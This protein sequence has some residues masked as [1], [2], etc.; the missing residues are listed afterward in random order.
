[1]NEFLKEDMNEVVGPLP[2]NSIGTVYTESTEGVSIRMSNVCAGLAD[3]VS[4]Y[5]ESV[6]EW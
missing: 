1:M 5:L 6:A 3:P 4:E 2:K